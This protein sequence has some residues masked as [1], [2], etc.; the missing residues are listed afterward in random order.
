VLTRLLDGVD[1]KIVA[2]IR[3]AARD[4]PGV[5]DIAEI[6]TRWLGH[7]LHAELNVAVDPELS[8][9]KSHLIAKAVHHNL[10]HRLPYLS[11]ATIHVDPGNASGE[12]YH[13]IDGHEHDDFPRHSH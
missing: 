10:L 11:K 7:R 2:D 13:G 8:V 5:R 9:W 4:T 6:R 3:H 12:A 1:P